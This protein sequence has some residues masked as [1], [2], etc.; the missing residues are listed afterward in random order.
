M[1]KSAVENP[2]KKRLALAEEWLTD[3]SPADVLDNCVSFYEDSIVFAVNQDRNI[4]YWNERASELLGYRPDEVLGQSCRKANRCQACMIGCSLS[5]RLVVE[6]Q[7]V[8]LY[9]ADGE[10]CSFLKQARAFLDDDGRFMG[11]IEILTPQEPVKQ[12]MPSLELAMPL[13]VT[14]E[15]ARLLSPLPVSSISP[16]RRRSWAM[17]HVEQFEDLL[18]RDPEMKRLLSSLR[19][20]ASTDATVLVH[21]ESGTGKELVARAIHEA[22]GR[23]KGPFVAV[24]CG[25][26]TPGLLESELFGYEKGAFTGAVGRRIGLFQRAQEGTI[27]LDE[28]AELPLDLQSKLLRVL[29]EREVMPLGALKPVR[30]DIRVISASHKHLPNEVKAGKFREDLM[31][32]LR[33]V[34]L[35]LPPLRER[36]GDIEI[37][38]WHFIERYN[39][40]GAR[41]IRQIAEDALSCLLHYRWHGNIRELRNVIEYTF[42]LGQGP[43]LKA[44]ELPPEIMRQKPVAEGAASQLGRRNTSVVHEEAASTQASNNRVAGPPSASSDDTEANRI[45]TVFTTPETKAFADGRTESMAPADAEAKGATTRVA[46]D[47]A[48]PVEDASLRLV[49]DD[50][51]EKA[52]IQQAL[53]QCGGNLGEAAALLGISRPTLWRKRKK[54]RL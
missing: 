17:E 22:S 52:R 54:Y 51:S 16:E 27:F 46:V 21:G 31:Y 19:Q 34:P 40:Q 11:G 26:L 53:S 1:T 13:Q 14:D 43:V 23:H 7:A 37:L 4:V 15:E 29:E 10:A 50:E 41:R 33:V 42:A 8:V 28:I 20:V 38:C 25:A 9:R 44:S 39:Q 3:L 18:T 2:V 12:S 48:V 32:R 36:P 5:E 45:E 49:L 47:D 24:N 6:E 35:S 30:V